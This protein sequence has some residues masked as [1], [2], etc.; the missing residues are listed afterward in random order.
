[1]GA[2]LVLQVERRVSW[3]RNVTHAV[4]LNWAEERLNLLLSPI[5]PSIYQFINPYNNMHTLANCRV[6][7]NPHHFVG[8][9][10]GANNAQQSAKPSALGLSHF[11]W[12]IRISEIILRP[13]VTLCHVRSLIE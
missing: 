12:V 8:W 2:I 11:E 7:L 1:M 4:L 3:T 9:G 5:Y 10:W 13:C 6:S